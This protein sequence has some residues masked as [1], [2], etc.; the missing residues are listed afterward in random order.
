[1][2]IIQLQ[3]ARSVTGTNKY[4]SKHLLYIKTGWDKRREK[5]RL[6]LLFKIINDMAP[7]HLLNIYNNFDNANYD[8]NLRNNKMQLIYSRTESFRSPFFPA[9]FRLWNE[10]EPSVRNASSLSKFKSLLCKNRTRKITTLIMAIEKKLH[11]VK[12]KNAL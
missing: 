1:M 4:S 3:A 6:I 8:Y 5:Q 11:I 12:Y 10:L 7:R 9:S 2:E